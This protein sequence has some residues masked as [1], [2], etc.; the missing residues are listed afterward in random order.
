MNLENNSLFS[1]EMIPFL[2]CENLKQIYLC[3][4]RA[5]SVV[6]LMK[7]KWSNLEKFNLRS[8]LIKEFR[9]GRMKLGQ[10]GKK[11]DAMS[12]ID[13]SDIFVDKRVMMKAESS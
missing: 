11:I 13:G 9:I 1:L 12:N 10:I 2:N 6:P 4:N 3:M 5:V 8:N 7:T